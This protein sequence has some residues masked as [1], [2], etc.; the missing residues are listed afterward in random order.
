MS[1]RVGIV[2]SRRRQDYWNIW[3]FV[4]A[5]PSGTVIISGGCKGPD[6][7]ATDHA[8]IKGYE[9]VEYLPDLPPDGS[10]RY[11]FTKAYYARNKKIAEDV[12][13]LYAFVAPDRK[14]GTENTI[15]YARELGKE[16]HI[17]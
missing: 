9:I 16:V 17:C 11:E 6:K 15:H 10:Q 4:E 8:K 1:K 14:G 3:E 2:G 5:L 12:D 13:V 7:W